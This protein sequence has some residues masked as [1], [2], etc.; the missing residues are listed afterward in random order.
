[1]K[2][3]RIPERKY[4]IPLMPDLLS[5]AI[6]PIEATGKTSSLERGVSARTTHREHVTTSIQAC[7]KLPMS[8]FR[9]I[10]AR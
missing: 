2:Y 3:Q 4:R 5:R 9:L 7:D 8:T 1:M 6:S 10:T